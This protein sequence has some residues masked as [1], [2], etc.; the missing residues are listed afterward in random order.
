[1]LLVLPRQRVGASEVLDGS[2]E[3]ESVVHPLLAEKCVACHGALKQEAGLRLDHGGLLRVGG[4]SGSVIGDVGDEASI[5]FRVSTSDTSLR[6]PPDGEGEMLSQTQVDELKH[7]ID[8]GALSPD[9]E[10]VPADP[11]EH[12]AWQSPQRAAVPVVASSDWNENPVDAFIHATR[13]RAGAQPAS[14]AKPRTRLRRLYFDLIGLPPTAAEQAAFIADPSDQQW[15]SEVE[16]LLNDAKHGERWARHWMDVWRYSDWDG[17]KNNLRGSQRHIWRWRDW[18]V[19]SLNADKGYDQMV[20]EMLAGDEIAGDDP[21]V[22]RATGFLARNFHTSNRNIWLDATV[23]H[24]SKAFLGLTVNC[25]RCH[26]HKYDPIGQGEYYALR[27]VFEPHQVRT[28]RIPG[29]PDLKENGIARVFDEKPEEPTYL[30]FAGDEKR[31]DKNNPVAPGVP[32]V[33]DLPYRVNPVQLP[34]LA[35]LPALADFI[36]TEDVQA[37]ERR[38]EGLEKLLAKVTSSASEGTEAGELHPALVSAG[39]AVVAA[40][41]DLD[42]LLARAASDRSRYLADSNGTPN[43]KLKVLAIRAEELAAVEN[44]QL[45]VIKALAKR[46]EAEV[47]SATE[48]AEPSVDSEKLLKAAKTELVQAEKVLAKATAN[49][50]KLKSYKSVGRV[51]PAISTGRRLGLARWI[52][53]RENPL[54]A[55]VAVNYVWLHHFGEPLVAN[56]FDFGLRSPRPKHAELLDWL[57]VE[58]MENGWSLKHLHRLI[59]RSRTYQLASRLSDESVTR[60]NE[61]VDRENSLLWRANI[62]RLDAE[63]IRDTLLYVGGDLDT[64]VGGPEIDFNQ[65][66]T[67]KRRSLYFR[68]AYEKQMTMLVLFDA[69]GP[70][71]CYRR[72]ESVIPQQALAIANNPLSFDQSRRLA[73]RLWNPPGTDDDLVINQAFI[74]LLGREAKANELAVCKQF[75]ARQSETLAGADQL[76]PVSSKT[77]STIPSSADPLQRARENLIHTLMNHNDFVTIR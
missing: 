56:V 6:M 65:G 36:Q 74:V 44:A 4:D 37:A 58:L 22:L 49:I 16:R 12:W 73:S 43:D 32:K 68:H 1:M 17:Y 52:V 45:A 20:T 48:K 3:Y 10:P 30:F 7:W 40:Q 26:D 38:I 53:D 18:I 39:Q 24:T 41:A 76:S 55:R 60:S 64:R 8:G 67:V 62:R 57:A 59:V 25:A 28:D 77:T 11:S 46:S 9:D 75:L 2:D 50:G 14:V 5:V 72:S 19:E 15:R 23:E 51:Y 42:S 63:S 34:P 70:T 71:E 27:A 13:I 33:V 47:E 66:E 29:Q 61:L 54:A 31:P 69:A 21:D 35:V